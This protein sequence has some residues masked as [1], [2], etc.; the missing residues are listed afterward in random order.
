[1]LDCP[2]FLDEVTPAQGGCATPSRLQ[3]GGPGF[4]AA[5]LRREGLGALSPGPGGAGSEP[6]REP[7]R[8]VLWGPPLRCVPARLPRPR[9]R[10]PGGPAGAARPSPPAHAPASGGSGPAFSA[11]SQ[12]PP[13]GHARRTC[14]AEDAPPAG[15]PARPPGRP[16]GSRAKVPSAWASGHRGTPGVAPPPPSPDA[17]S[18]HSSSCPGARGEGWLRP[19]RFTR[20]LPAPRGPPRPA[21]RRVTRGRRT[22]IHAQ[23]TEWKAEGT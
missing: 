16:P 8:R 20:R 3:Q 7:G 12:G 5:R 13:G 11:R 18:A 10:A 22:K 1:M 9:P 2:G 17:G 21:P 4:C 15:S 23:G 19:N 14:R 6:L